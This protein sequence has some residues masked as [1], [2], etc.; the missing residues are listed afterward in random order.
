M[1]SDPSAL[2]DEI[3]SQ[4][5]VLR[6]FLADRAADVVALGRTLADTG[7]HAAVIVARGSSDNAARYAQYAFGVAAG[8][9]VTLAAPSLHTRYGAPPRYE[10]AA[11][12]AVSQSGQSPDVVAVLEDAR[13]QG[14]PTVAITNAPESPLAGVADHVIELGAGP[15]TSVAATKTYTTSLLAFACLAAGAGRA[16]DA[17]LDELAAVP[18]AVAEVSRPRPEHDRAAALIAA[19]GRSLTV[20]RGYNLSTA[21]EIALKV[22]ELTGTACQPYSSADLLHGPIASAGAETPVIVVAPSGAVR[23]DVLATAAQA[24]ERGT[25]TVVLSDDLDGLSAVDVGLPLPTLPEWLSPIAAVVP[26]QILA[27]LAARRRGVEVDRPHGLS[28]VTETR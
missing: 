12:I 15:E 27:M 25:T 24:R 16:T 8:W 17:V 20:G 19:A 14:C 26:G 3:S 22:T 1:T 13:A 23:D 28:K 21:F 6:R 18:A 5:D 10:H 4:S 2:A 11:V 9:P 7:C